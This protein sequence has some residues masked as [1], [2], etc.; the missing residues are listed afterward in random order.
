MKIILWF[1]KITGIIPELFYFRR[2]KYYKNKLN[3]KIKSPVIFVSNH[4]SVMDFAL[5]LFAFFG[6]TVRPIAAEILYKK[7]AFMNFMLKSV[8]AIKVERDKFD[9]NFINESINYLN[10]GQNIIIFPEGRIPD[11]KNTIIDFKPS[12]VEMALEAQVPIVPLYTNGSY[13]KFK[14]AKMVIGEPINV[15]DLY[16]NN[17]SQKENLYNI[18]NYVRNYII[19]LG[20][21]L[22]AEEQK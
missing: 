4:T 21:I 18:S 1:I 15:I 11:E 5:Y 13:G 20:D 19:E 12:F 2:K 22:H 8:G 17:L 7:N 10:K 9:F 6:K 16:D 14:R 3:K